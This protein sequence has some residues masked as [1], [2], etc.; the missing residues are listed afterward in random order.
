MAKQLGDIQTHVNPI[1]VRCT[2]DGDLQA[3]LFDTG[4]IN[5]S[6][7]HSQALSL[8]SAR[9]LNYLSNFTAEKSC[10]MLMTT[11]KDEYFNVSN[12]YVYTKPSRNSFPQ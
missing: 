7:L 12:I 10:L 4:T 9:S 5:N 3:I 11:E 2:G 1:R 6:V 8:T